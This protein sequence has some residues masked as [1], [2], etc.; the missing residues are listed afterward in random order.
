M[1]KI[2]A[3]ALVL[4]FATAITSFA[5]T[6]APASANQGK[7]IYG[8]IAS[9]PTATDDAE[10]T[11]IGKCS[12]GVYAG[13]NTTASAYTII[14][15]H[16]DGNRSFGSSYDA[17]AIYRNDTKPTDAPDAADKSYFA[18]GWTAM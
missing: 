8:K 2:F 18:D 11:L 12:K 3:L 16:F 9:D 13:W 4:L 6:E 14:T 15:M 5:D 1:K 10:A 7:S 17:T